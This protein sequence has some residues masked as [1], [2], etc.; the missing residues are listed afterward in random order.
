LPQKN[1]ELK[2]QGIWAY[3]GGQIRD[4]VVSNDNDAIEKPL[5]IIVSTSVGSGFLDKKKKLVLSRN[6]TVC[7]LKEVLRDKF[8]GGPPLDLQKLFFGSRRLDDHEVISNLTSASPI[9]LLLDMIAGTSAY[10]RTLS[11]A[12]SLEAYTASLTQQ[13]YLGDKLRQFYATEAGFDATS[14]GSTDIIDSVVYK[15]MFRAINESIYT[16]YGKEI[17]AA[18]L[19]EMDPEVESQDTLRWRGDKKQQRSPLAIAVAKEFDLNARSLK[20]FFY[21]SI[22]LVVFP[23]DIQFLLYINHQIHMLQF[24]LIDSS[25]IFAKYG[26]SSKS[27]SKYLIVFIPILWVSKLRQIRFIYKVYL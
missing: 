2:K 7:D 3:R 25:Q 23:C 19:A 12:E 22:L 27:S 1:K 10:N 5:Q 21:Y 9:P 8:P 13:A 18:L 26:T 6:S 11:V 16:T 14:I 24:V 20:M 15:E 17:E 4:E